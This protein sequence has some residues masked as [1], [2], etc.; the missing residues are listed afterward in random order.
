MSKTTRKASIDISVIKRKTREN[1][2]PLQK[3][4]GDLVARTWKRLKYS[5]TFSCQSS[6][7]QRSSYTSQVSEEKGRDREH[8]E[9]PTIEAVQA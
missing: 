5:R 6:S 3:K 2:G 7:A 4:M 9:P 1:V 8:E